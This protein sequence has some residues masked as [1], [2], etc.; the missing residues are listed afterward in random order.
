MSEELLRALMQL[1]ALASNDDDLTN[2]SRIIVERFLSTELGEEHIPQYLKLYDKFLKDYQLVPGNNQ[3]SLQRDEV[4]DVC[5]NINQNLVQKQKLI[6]LLRLLEYILADGNISQHEI[7]FIKNLAETFNIPENE[8]RIALAFASA[9]NATIPDGENFMLIQDEKV[10]LPNGT[11]FLKSSHLEGHIII[12]RFES[13]SLFMIR[14]FGN[15]ILQLN[16][17][18]I[19]PNRMY[20]FNN[21]SSV[22]SSK[23]H[24]VF[25]SDVISAFM[26]IN[27][28]EKLV[29]EVENIEY[30]FKTGNK[31]LQ[32]LSFTEQ[33]GRMIGIMGGSGAGKSTLLNILNGNYAPTTGSVKI[34]NTDIHKE[35]SKIEGV[36]GYVSQDDLLMEDLTVFQNLYFNAKLCFA[37]ESDEVI[38]KR[39]NDLLEQLGLS[40]SKNLKVGN[41]IDKVISGGQRKR[42]NIALEL[43]REPAVLFVD[44]PTSGL[45]SRDSENI[46]DLL[47]QLAL[48]G[49]LVFVVIHQP[50]SDIFKMF[51]RLLIL[52]LGGFPIYYGDAVESILYFKQKTN[53]ITSQESEC[54]SCGNVNPE[55][56][57]NII[58]SKVVDEYGNVTPNRKISPNQWNEYFHQNGNQSEKDPYIPKTVPV[59]NL[60]TPGLFGQFRIFALRDLLSKL[61]N[62]QYLL[63]NLLEAPILAA[64]LSYFIKF[65]AN[66]ID[67]RHNYALIDNENMPAYLFMAVV[68]A[69]FIGLTVSAEEIIRDQK[70]RKRE[71]FLNLSKGSYL[72]SKILILFSLS[73]IQM[74]TFVLI[75]NLVMEI[76]GMNW[77]YWLILFT[78]ACFANM[79]G[80]NISSA[81]NSAVT[82][83]IL[84]PFLIIPQLIFSG[85]IVKFDKL[86]PT[87]SS[88]SHVPLIGEI[89]ASRWAF[90]ALA[91]TQYKDN[92]SEK[93]VYHIDKVLSA[94]NYRKVYWIPEIESRINTIEAKTIT[95]AIDDEMVNAVLLVKNE[96]ASPEKM[97]NYPA[98]D[99]AFNMENPKTNDKLILDAKNYVEKL[100]KYLNKEFIHFTDKKDNV[101]YEINKN[102]NDND[103]Y[104]ML[105]IS[106]FNTGLHDLLT[107]RTEFP[108][109]I[110][111]DKHLMQNEDPIFV[112]ADEF[113]A[114]FF[115][116][117]KKIFN[118]MIDT[119]WL[120][121][122]VLWSMTL[123]LGLTLYIDLLRKF[124]G[125]FERIALIKKLRSSQ[126]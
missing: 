106:H 65:S 126:K 60:K 81:F 13:V 77:R 41:P 79:L 9:S 75:G 107:K 51:D 105:K 103:A 21:G 86:N 68:V 100:R 22:R 5:A 48:K 53:Q 23:M 116:P 102:A 55:Q 67:E 76:D 66:A 57:F 85:V 120:N 43:I 72:W 73:A 82:I 94:I 28:K 18:P 25:Y 31:G 38:T 1:F 64:I 70:I 124:I 97:L 40:E 71:S 89:M 44:E 59:S 49:K 16:G 62:K 52:D 104:N 90:E 7:E 37:N 88:K 17:Q 61:S 117:R 6:V 84:I 36:I 58:E 118:M 42:L 24:P 33:N 56:I 14:Y 8:Y 32:P 50:S 80:L 26:D 114:H 122:M 3:A 11:R 95:G 98:F 99:F 78:T 111:V 30:V 35:K 45:S 110:E 39:V 87:V 54:G 101:I 74:I 2:E 19:S 29:F 92:P 119:F 63:I 121:I 4:K 125:I 20:V 96:L 34:N 91:V 47:K 83:Y 15:T 109:I 93:L 46:M 115:A 12:S 108:K 69:L 27:F 113:R 112:D 123:V 10:F